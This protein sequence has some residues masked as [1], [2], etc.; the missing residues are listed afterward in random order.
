[1]N[2]LVAEMARVNESLVAIENAG[3]KRLKFAERELELARFRT[4]INILKNDIETITVLARCGGR[5]PNV[6][7]LRDQ[8]ATK[9]Q[10]LEAFKAKYQQEFG[11]PRRWWQ[12]WK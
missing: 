10:E 8:L 6:D 5:E 1:M 3:L 9:L 2:D 12:F 4:E 7:N 11:K